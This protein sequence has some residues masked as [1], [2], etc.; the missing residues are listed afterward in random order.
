MPPRR[1][2]AA[3]RCRMLRGGGDGDHAGQRPARGQ[4]VAQ[5]ALADRHRHARLE[6]A[7]EELGGRAAIAVRAVVI[8]AIVAPGRGAVTGRDR[9]DP[10]RPRGDAELREMPLGKLAQ[11]GIAATDRLLEPPG[12]AA[13]W[14]PQPERVFYAGA[15]AVEE[16]VERGGQPSRQRLVE[17]LAALAAPDDLAQ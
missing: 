9:M 2:G 4:D 14:R 7:P 8:L 16:A 12:H 3:T 17:R 13:A 15:A 10:A 5:L 11:G 1:R 6:G